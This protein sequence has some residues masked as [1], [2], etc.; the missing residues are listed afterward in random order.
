MRAAT[1]QTARQRAASSG[2]KALREGARDDAQ[3]KAAGLDGGGL[4][5]GAEH[6]VRSAGAAPPLHLVGIPSDATKG[7]N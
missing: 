7:F 4:A 3:N 1:Q 2:A 6:R 5:A